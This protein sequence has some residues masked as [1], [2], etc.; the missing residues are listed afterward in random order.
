VR[1]EKGTLDVPGTWHRVACDV[2]HYSGKLYLIAVDCGPSRLAIWRKIPSEA[3]ESV[4]QTLLDIFRE[5]GPPSELLMDNSRTFR[6]ARVA[7]LCEKWGVR[8]IYRCANRPSGNGIVER[9]HRIIKRMAARTGQDP[10]DMVFWYNFTPKTGFNGGTAPA[11]GCFSYEWRCPGEEPGNLVSL[12]PVQVNPSLA[13]GEKVFVKPPNA[14]CTTQWTT[15]E[16]TDVGGRGPVEVDGV[17]RHPADIRSIPR[18]EE[19]TI[20]ENSNE[21]AETARM[22]RPHRQRQKPFYL[23]DYAS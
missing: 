1:W 9:N 12:E 21:A 2:T 19:A 14:R 20:E 6:S 15:G 23:R 17:P 5:R 10:L 16:V 22:T 13:L 11:S 4:A 18:R 8:R 3:E 7:S